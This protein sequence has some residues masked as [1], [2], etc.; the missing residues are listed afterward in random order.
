MEHVGSKML[1]AAGTVLALGPPGT[2]GASGYGWI[3]PQEEK[4]SL[5]L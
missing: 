1:V 3:H 5:W 4:E 2:A